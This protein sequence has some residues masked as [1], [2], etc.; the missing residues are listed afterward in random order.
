VRSPTPASPGLTLGG[1]IGWLSRRHGLA[2]DNLVGAEL[3]QADGSVIDVDAESDPELFWALRG[4]GGF[5]H[6]DRVPLPV[7]P[8]AAAVRG[9]AA[10][11]AAD[12]PRVLECYREFA[13]E[14]PRDLSL[15]AAQL[16]APRAP[17]VPADLQLQP[18]VAVP[19]MWTGD[20]LDGPDAV[21]WLGEPDAS[22]VEQLAVSA[23]EFSSPYNQ[24]LVRRLGGAIADV[25]PDAT[26]FRFRESSYM[27]TIASGWDGG[28]DDAHVAWTRRSW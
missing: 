2:C 12:T 21:A 5:R 14:A 9:H 28:D 17:F 19:S 23:A 10:L 1:G 6:R 11:A 3:V 7:A 13:R 20:P 18:V 27:L 25:A 24:V 22:A 8:R 16:V 4:G 26:A 15:V